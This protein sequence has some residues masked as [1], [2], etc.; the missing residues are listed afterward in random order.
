[1]TDIRNLRCLALMVAL[2]A[3]CQDSAAPKRDVML[4][5]S[6]AFKEDFDVPFAQG[7]NVYGRYCSVCHG[8]QGKGDGFNAFNLNPRPRNFTD[9]AFLARLDERLVRETIA[10]G[11]SAV[12]LSPLMPPWGHTLTDRDI[13]LV[14]QYVEYLAG[15]ATR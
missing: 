4:E 3:S 15:G 11:G 1:M 7:R 12:G 8:V 9:S 14:S 2:L 10:K 6:A 5:A 13:E